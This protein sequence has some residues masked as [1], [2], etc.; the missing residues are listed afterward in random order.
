MESRN[1]LGVVPQLDGFISFTSCLDRLN[2]SKAAFVLEAIERRI[3]STWLL[4]LCVDENI[5]INCWP[6]W[7]RKL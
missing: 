7:Y 2:L 6:R 5:L 4:A 3:V 1:V